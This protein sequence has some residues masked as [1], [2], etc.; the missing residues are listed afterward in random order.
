MMFFLSFTFL[1]YLFCEVQ[2]M[3][4][5]KYKEINSNTYEVKKKHLSVQLRI[6]AKALG[7][8]ANSTMPSPRVFP[9]SSI[10]TY[11]LS[12]LPKISKERYNNSFETKG[13]RF[14]TRTVQ[15]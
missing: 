2:I 11:A 5:K 7:L 9:L 12:I 6:A 8:R 1:I 15:L 14:F 4:V 13:G 10:F 3:C